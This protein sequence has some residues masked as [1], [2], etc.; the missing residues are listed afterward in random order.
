MAFADSSKIKKLILLIIVLILCAGCSK[1]NNKIRVISDNNEI[2]AFCHQ[3][4]Y[5][6]K[7]IEYNSFISLN[8]NNAKVS[9]SVKET[10]EDNDIQPDCEY[11]RKKIKEKYGDGVSVMCDYESKTATNGRKLYD[12]ELKYWYDIESNIKNEMEKLE[13]KDYKCLVYYNKNEPI[14]ND[15]IIG[16][17]CGN[18]PITKIDHK[19]TFNVDGTGI[20]TF[21]KQNLKENLYYAINGDNLIKYFT[22]EKGYFLNMLYREE[23]DT[24]IGVTVNPETGEVLQ[25]ADKYLTVLSRC[26]S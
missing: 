3:S 12:Y 18:D 10:K 5:P 11:L 24:I 19:Y 9:F 1:N 22:I 7:N 25:V 20:D 17:W 26:E 16:S 15:K 6:T 14:K 8:G 13:K 4:S 23:S 2:K 21:G